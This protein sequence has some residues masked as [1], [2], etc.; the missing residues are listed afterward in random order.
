MTDLVPGIIATEFNDIAQKLKDYSAP[1]WLSF[2]F[3]NLEG[4]IL[5]KPKNTES[6]IDLNA[7]LEFYSR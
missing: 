2:D 3:N 6:F 1:A 4:R 5:D 7:V